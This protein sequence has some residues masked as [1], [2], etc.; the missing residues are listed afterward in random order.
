MKTH[1]FPLKLFFAVI[2]PLF[3]S[4]LIFFVKFKPVEKV[5]YKNSKYIFNTYN[6]FDEGG[7]ST[8]YVDVLDK[9]SLEVTY[10]LSDA[11][12]YPNISLEFREP[13]YNLMDFSGYDYIEIDIESKKSKFLALQFYLYIEGYTES[14]NYETFLPLAYYLE[15][16]KSNGK[17]KIPLDQFKP[18]TWWLSR[19]QISEELVKN[20]SFSSVKSM[21]IM[22]DP[23]FPTGVEDRIKFRS[24]SFHTELKVIA[25][26]ILVVLCL[27]YTVYFTAIYILKRFDL[28]KQNRENIVL[29]PYKSTELPAENSDEHS[30]ENF[31]CSNYTDPLLNIAKVEDKTGLSERVISKILKDKYNYSFPGFINFLRI[32]EAKKLL[33]SSDKKILDIAMMVG[34]NSLGHFNR[35]FKKHESSTPREFRKSN[36][37]D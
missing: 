7:A 25:I 18:H 12:T 22:N 32:T 2:L 5:E 27:Y 1:L 26:I 36:L 20:Y 9:S 29:V 24:V 28:V 23:S 17:Y 35:T 19:Y 21:D 30:I 14:D 16:N 31:I 11:A 33:V 3:I 34:Y 6:D 15:L 37:Q 8:V 10:T 4:I 13:D